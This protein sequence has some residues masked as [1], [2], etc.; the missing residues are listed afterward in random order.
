[1]VTLG[2]ILIFANGC[3]L[4]VSN[5][6]SGDEIL[7]GSP[8]LRLLAQTLDRHYCLRCH[9]DYSNYV[10]EGD[11][12]DAGLLIPGDSA[13]SVLIKR[14][15]GDDPAFSIMPPDGVVVG[16]S[17]IQSLEDWIDNDLSGG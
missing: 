5:N 2:L 13:S 1:M 10:T 7:T 15:R 14:L 6:F 8:S 4:R 3:F 17:V 9:V 16:E 12:I 11:W